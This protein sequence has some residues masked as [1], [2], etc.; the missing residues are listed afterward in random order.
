MKPETLA[1]HTR[2][3]VDETTGAIAPPLVLSTTFERNADG[4]TPRGYVYTRHNNPNRQAL[5]D[6]LTLLEGGAQAAAFASGLSAIM[7]VFHAL[8]PGEQ[9]IFSLDSYFAGRVMLETL[10]GRWG[11]R[12]SFVD[13]SE[14]ANVQQALQPTTRLVW[15]ETPS[16]PNLKITDI[17]QVAAIAHQAG[18]RCVVD[19]TW[20]T[21]ILQQ[22]LK[23]GADMVMHSTTKYLAGHSDVLGGA[24][25][26]R[27]MDEFF[28]RVQEFQHLGGAVPSPFDCWLIQRNLPSLPVHLRAH[29]A[30][31]HAVAQFLS[32]HPKVAKVHYPGLPTHPNHAIA[33]KQ[34]VGGFGGML[35]FE[36]HG[37]RAEAYAVIN[38]LKLF[39]HA[40]SLGGVESLIEHRA[41]AEGP[42][43]QASE[44]LLRVSIGLE[45]A[46]DLIDDLREALS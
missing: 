43:T 41:T 20:A 7:S 39:R 12:A 4:T 24:I 31:A 40:T 6:A 35:S 46:D 25:I 23:L 38:R 19:N 5:E 32:Q 42:L 37:G 34:M 27:T 11:L 26:T 14:A 13:M 1:V 16:N 45:H 9:V 17:E 21:P 15:V 2:A 3:A 44:S 29:C 10:Y 28:Q 36:P 18:A 8:A 30:T 33:A 22:P